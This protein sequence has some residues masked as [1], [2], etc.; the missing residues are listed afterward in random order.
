MCVCVCLRVRLSVHLSVC[1]S[2]RLSV[3]LSVKSDA[4]RTQNTPAAILAPS[5]RFKRL[6]DKWENVCVLMLNAV[7]LGQSRLTVCLMLLHLHK[8]LLGFQFDSISYEDGVPQRTVE[9]L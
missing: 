9:C 7:C 8:I 1:L 4:V 2:L 3:C 5:V 6:N